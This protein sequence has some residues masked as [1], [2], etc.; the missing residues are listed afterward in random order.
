MNNEIMSDTSKEKIIFGQLGELMEKATVTESDWS[1][2]NRDSTVESLGLDSLSILDLLY[3]IEQDL[4]IRVEAEEVVEMGTM[5]E[6]V[7][8]LIKKGA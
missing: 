4:G 2:V 1:D 6:I 7:D 5:G 8:L 3:D